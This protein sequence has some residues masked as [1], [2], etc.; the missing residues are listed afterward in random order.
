VDPRDKRIA[1]LERQVAERDV[2]IARLEAALDK[3][4]ERIA[5]LEAK[6][7]QNSSNSS[8]PPSKDTP[9]QRRNRDKGKPSGRKRGGQ[10]G[11]KPQ[12]REMLPPEKVTHIENHYPH[13]CEECG[14][15]LDAISDL[16]PWR[17]QVL[18]LPEIRPEVIEHRLHTGHCEEC[19]HRTRAPLPT[20]VPPSMFGPRL[21]ALVALLTG[22]CRVSRRQTV[23][24]LNDVLGIRV[25][26][27]ALSEAEQRVSDAVAPAVAEALL[28]VRAQPVKHV[29]ATTWATAGAYRALWTVSTTLVTVF[30]ITRD[31][32]QGT[33]QRLLAQARGLLVTDR[34]TVFGFWAMQ[35]RQICWA[36]LLRKFAS[37]VD[38]KGAGSQIARQLQGT[39]EL[40]FHHWHR[41]RDGTMTRREF[42]EWMTPV[43]QRV[44]WL[45][46]RGVAL[47]ARGVSGACADILAHRAALWAF[48]DRSDVEPTNNLAE[49]DLRP[50]VQWRKTCFG[51]QSDRGERYAERIMTVTHTLRKQERS[52]FEYL[53]RAC[54]N[55]LYANP[56]ESL[57]PSSA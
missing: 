17:H 2:R 42:R 46:E 7:G 9:E 52:V 37:L 8:Q 48:V 1:E 40:I 18:D 43:R 34:A 11:H 36:H 22:T 30:M 13:E 56:P 20:G 23:S 45:L 5:V 51:T 57:L 47:R 29:D 27:G 44:E 55:Q 35:R 19:G 24:F 25:S 39:A 54:A 53:H 10:P 6:L 41:V 16:E 12:S 28:F 15:P 3:A 4:L 38:R 33:V 49:R 14:S 50:F 31:G 26:L 32:T 21:L